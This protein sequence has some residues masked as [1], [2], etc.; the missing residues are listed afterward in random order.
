MG[1][2]TFQIM[3]DLHLETPKS[4]PSY[5]EFT[6]DPVSPNLALL[7]DIGEAE[8]EE[9]FDFLKSQLERFERVFF[10][11]GNHEAYGMRHAHAVQRMLS[12]EKCVAT[13]SELGEFVFLH[14][15]RYDLDDTTT[16]LGCTL[17][18]HITPAQEDSVSRFVSDFSEIEDW[19]VALHNEAHRADLQWLNDEVGKISCAEPRRRIVVFSHHSPTRQAQANDPR[20]FQDPMEIA[21]AFVTDLQNEAC[22]RCSQVELWAFGHT[23]FNCDFEDGETGK[24]IVANQKGYR[25]KE[26]FSFNP[27]FKITVPKS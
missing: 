25:R 6:F 8:H 24:R 18:S 14:R 11:L 20:K 22:W 4:R 1:E 2:T 26:I 9:L 27:E 12:F 17:H 23:H 13:K 7:G 5:G 19:S 15:R 21:S 16:V 3:S 10:V